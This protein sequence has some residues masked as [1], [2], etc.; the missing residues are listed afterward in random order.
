MDGLNFLLEN[1]LPLDEIKR[2]MD[3]DDLTLD[4]IVESAKRIIA[5]GDH[6][7]FSSFSSFS[8]DWED[9]IPFD[10]IDTPPFPVDCLPAP[11]AAYVDELAESTQTPPEMSATMVLG[12]LGIAFQRRY[13]VVINPDWVEPLCLY[14]LSIAAPGERKSAVESA[15]TKPV[16]ACEAKQRDIEAVEIMQNRAERDL[17]EKRLEAVKKTAANAKNREQMEDARSEMLELSAQL[18]EFKDLHPT[19]LIVDDTTPEKLVDIM[20]EQGGSIAI[21]SSEGGIFDAMAGRYDRTYNF[22]V[23][24]KAFS[25]DFISIDRIGRKSNHVE[26]PRL[27]MAL[28][29]QPNVIQGLMSNDVFRGRGLCGRFLYAVCRSRVGHRKVSPA[30]VTPETKKAYYDFVTRILLDQGSG[31]VH[32]SQEADRLREEYQTCIEARLLN[33]LESMQDWGNKITGTMI[34]IAALLHLSSFPASEPISAETM[35][36]AIK[37]AEFYFIH[38]QAAYQV[39]GADES[40]DGAKYAWKRI[41]GADKDQISRSEIFNLCRGRFKK[42]DDLEPVLQ[43][44]IDMGYMK[45]MLE[46]TGGRPKKM[47]ALNPLRKSRKSRKRGLSA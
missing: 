38:A 16:F 23:Y 27:T 33:E 17:L 11:A 39:M 43:I 4:Q 40:M 14:L 12:V 47:Y 42:A 9:P 22:D 41:D 46:E 10:E 24:L 13:V 19:R 6:L 45:E 1:G 18:A 25:G 7:T 44:L 3:H 26:N 31:E 36:A 30:P 32:L 35:T 5:R 2:L 37:I 15:T 21:V 34:R 28:T 20:N 8:R 29:V